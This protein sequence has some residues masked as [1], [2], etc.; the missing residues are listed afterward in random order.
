VPVEISCDVKG[1]VRQA[2]EL[3]A[4]AI[5]LLELIGLEKVELSLLLTDDRRIAQINHTFRRKSGP[6]DVLSFSQ[7]E[8]PDGEVPDVDEVLDVDKDSSRPPG[9]NLIGDVVISLETAARQAR[10]MDQSV[11]RRLRTLLVHG[12]LHLMGLDHERSAAD[13]KAMFAVQDRLEVKLESAAAPQP[14]ARKS[15]R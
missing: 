3:R 10:E 11:S 8:R 5:K 7:L 9:L 12:V 4:A 14:T 15:A 13:A 6:T 1:G 2:R